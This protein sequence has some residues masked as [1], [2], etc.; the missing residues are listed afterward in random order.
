MAEPFT[1]NMRLE[2][3]SD[4]GDHQYSKKVLGNVML[5]WLYETAL[6]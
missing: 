5:K 1:E 2:I 6:I 3:H 4:L